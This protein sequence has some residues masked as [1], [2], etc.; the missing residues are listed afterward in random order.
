MRTR[1]CRRNIC[2]TLLSVYNPG[3]YC[4][5]HTEATLLRNHGNGKGTNTLD[6]EGGRMSGRFLTGIPDLLSDSDREA[7]RSGEWIGVT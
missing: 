2:K 3:P 7:I 4:W 6:V 1:I 5:A